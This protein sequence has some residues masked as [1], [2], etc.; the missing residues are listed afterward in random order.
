[1]TILLM[2]ASCGTSWASQ[3]RRR[4]RRGGG[5]GGGGGGGAAAGGAASSSS[6]AVAVVEKAPPQPKIKASGFFISRGSVH[7]AEQLEAIRVREEQRAAYGCSQR[8]RRQNSL[9]QRRR[10]R[11]VRRMATRLMVPLLMGSF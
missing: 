10:L 11:V 5:G 8:G 9:V 6:A 3:K 4:R 1:M 2:I 7:S